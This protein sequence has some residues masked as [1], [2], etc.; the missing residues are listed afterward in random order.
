M[1]LI[2][3][4][5]SVQRNELSSKIKQALKHQMHSFSDIDD[6]YGIVYYKRKDN[7]IWRVPLPVTGREGQQ[8]FVQHRSNYT[9]VHPCRLQ[10]RS[11]STVRTADIS[12]SCNEK[13]LFEVIKSDEPNKTRF[14]TNQLAKRSYS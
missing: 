2:M 8:V 9:W 1:C 12:A 5:K 14:W 11:N 3:L 10:L 13:G 7:P 6:E 4:G